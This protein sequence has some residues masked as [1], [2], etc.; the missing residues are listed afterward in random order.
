PPT[1]TRTG[2]TI[3]WHGT[4]T[5]R[6]PSS[7]G[8]ARNGCGDDSAPAYRKAGAQGGTWHEEE[9]VPCD[10]V[11]GPGAPRGPLRGP[12]RGRGRRKREECAH[13]HRV[14]TGREGRVRPGLVSP[15]GVGGSD[16]RGVEGH[17]RTAPRAL[18][19]PEAQSSGHCGRGN[20]LTTPVR[21]THPG[22]FF[23]RTPMRPVERDDR[24]GGDGAGRHL[25]R[26]H[27]SLAWKAV[28]ADRDRVGHARA[29]PRPA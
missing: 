27:G 28:P 5:R 7:C 3:R 10:M 23:Y 4:S 13:D 15:D 1:S 2:T 8:A 22:T 24:S 18:A 14:G 6:T 29:V 12:G 9:L 17:P 19:F 20:R 16:A 25:R 26:C 11:D 21:A